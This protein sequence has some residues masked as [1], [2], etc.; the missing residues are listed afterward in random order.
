VTALVARLTFVA[1]Q[2]R[3]LPAAAAAALVARLTFVA[4][5]SRGLVGKSRTG[6]G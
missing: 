4:E 3:R 6:G 2:P 5:L 1:E